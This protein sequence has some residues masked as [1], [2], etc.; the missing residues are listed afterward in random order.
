MHLLDPKE[1]PKRRKLFPFPRCSAVVNNTKQDVVV[2]RQMNFHCSLLVLRP[3]LGKSNRG[4]GL[5]WVSRVVV[6][7]SR[8]VG[9]QSVLDDH[10]YSVK[11]M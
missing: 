1:L 9:T 4:A 2:A 10:I 6:L 7:G 8:V 11:K 5:S 3:L